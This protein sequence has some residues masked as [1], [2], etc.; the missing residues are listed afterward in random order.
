[1]PGEE[2]APLQRL[3]GTAAQQVHSAHVLVPGLSPTTLRQSGRDHIMLCWDRESN[4]L[5]TMDLGVFPLVSINTVK[6]P[7]PVTAAAL[8]E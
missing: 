8:P 2:E 3:L 6:I 7:I 1:M 5:K 4:C